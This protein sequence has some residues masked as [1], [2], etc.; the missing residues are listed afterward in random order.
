LNQK[1][2]SAEEM[3]DPEYRVIKEMQRKTFKGEYQSL[4]NH[5]QL[6]TSGKL[7][8]LCPKLDSEGVMMSDG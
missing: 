7:L 3:S 1:E 2:L 8:G 5:K 6:T 4:V